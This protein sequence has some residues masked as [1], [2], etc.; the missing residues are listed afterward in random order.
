MAD[1]DIE[2]LPSFN[3]PSK[4]WDGTK[5]LKSEVKYILVF[6]T[7]FRSW[8]WD[9]LEVDSGMFKRCP[10][11]NCKI[12]TNKEGIKYKQDTYPR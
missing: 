7:F 2:F 9:G 3:N 12:A 4:F 10:V 11:S 8:G 5:I 6:T 1:E